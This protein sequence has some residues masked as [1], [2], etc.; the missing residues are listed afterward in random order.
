MPSALIG[1][2]GFVGGNLK[3]Q[4]AFDDLYRS[5]DVH[6]LAGKSYGLVVCAGATSL[7]W[8]A[9]REP[10]ADRQ[11][12]GRLIDALGTVRAERFIL[13]STIDVYDAPV[14]VDED[15]AVN[16]Q[17]MMPYGRHRF[18]LEQFVTQRFEG[19][20]VVRLPNLFGDGLKKNPVFDLL[21]HNEVHKLHQ[22]AVLQW[23]G[24]DALW[25]DITRA[26][27]A[28]IRL[29]NLATEPIPS[30]DLAR[31]FFGVELPQQLPPPAPNYDFSSRHAALW[32]GERGYLYSR[33]AIE[34]QLGQFVRREQA[35]MA[36][37]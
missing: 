37:R 22:D 3:A 15:S 23:Y 29:L 6:T 13:I 27:E 9:N 31:S 26:A 36:A 34:A 30:R 28:G 18:E 4:G 12:I 10:E 35:R 33:P 17:R 7:K 19:A 24:L 11:G 21:H 8:K 2:S 32:G 1:H 25:K 5:T 14:G 16:P 20:M